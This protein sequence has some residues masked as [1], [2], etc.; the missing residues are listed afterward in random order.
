[1][2]SGNQGANAVKSGKLLEKKIYE[3]FNDIDNIL[4][5]KSPK[6]TADWLK[7]KIGKSDFLIKK[8]NVSVRIEAKMKLVPGSDYQKIAYFIMC[9]RQGKFPEDKVYII[10]DGKWD[11]L[12][13]GLIDDVD[14]QLSKISNK[15]RGIRYGSDEYNLLVNNMRGI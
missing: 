10:F 8:K 1:M 7:S 6:Y 15:Y 2:K 4:I 14:N 3:D 13:P 11:E 9:A 12:N 5:E